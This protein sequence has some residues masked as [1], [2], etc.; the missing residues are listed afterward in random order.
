LLDD[1]TPTQTRISLQVSEMGKQRLYA[2][3][4]EFSINAVSL[5]PGAADG[6]PILYQD[7]IE[8]IRDELVEP[9]PPGQ[10]LPSHTAYLLL[11]D[12]APIL[13]RYTLVIFGSVQPDGTLNPPPP[14]GDDSPRNY[15]SNC[16]TCRWWCRWF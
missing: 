6:T 13:P 10:V 8:F 12:G 2:G 7:G 16:T 5:L 4:E 15:C 11:S 1:L 9:V 14:G 3:G